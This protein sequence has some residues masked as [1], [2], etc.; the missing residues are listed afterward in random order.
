[1]L[2]ATVSG[3]PQTAPDHD[4]TPLRCLTIRPP[5]SDLIAIE[6]DQSGKRIE[7]RVWTTLMGSSAVIHGF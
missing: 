4:R 3:R 7:N 6:D 2:L 5:W 1:M